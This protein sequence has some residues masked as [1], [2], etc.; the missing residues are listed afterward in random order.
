MQPNNKRSDRLGT[1][2]IVPLLLKLSVP[3]IIGMAIQAL[4]NVV[5]SI[6]IGRLSKE[7][8]SALSLAFPIQMV[9]IAVAVGTGIGTSALISRLLGEK[10]EHEAN[11]AAEH[12]LIITLFY[13]VIFGII[14]F[15]YSKELLRLFTDNGLL[16]E[17]GSQ[18]IR[19]IMIGSVAM[20]FP[21][22]SNNILRGE[23]NTFVPML[24]MLIGAIINIVLDPFLIFGIGFFPALG[25]E[26]AAYA[27]VFSR[28]IS[29]TFI[30]YILLFSNRNQLT[31]NIRDFQF[32]PKVLGAIYQV[33]LPAMIMQLLAS[34]MIGG[35]NKIVAEYSITAIAVV[36]IYFRLQ[37]F[38]F[39]PVFGLNQGYI[40]IMGYNY[41]HGQSERMKETFKYGLLISFLFTSGGFL[42][43]QIFPKPLISLF[44][45]D[46]E[47]IRIGTTALR[48][49]SLAFPI[50]G[51]AILGSTTFQAIGKG[52]PSLI[53]SILRQL[54]LLLPIML[55]L[56]KLYGLSALWFAFPLSE[57]VSGVLMVFWLTK[58]LRH[59]FAR[60]E[61]RKV[62]EAKG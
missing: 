60:M 52:M 5:D 42:L 33:G 10:K 56:G 31:L 48:R 8:L 55:I 7:A 22:I 35:V 59:V 21:M 30:G 29:G 25:V 32:D 28:I 37:S 62:V 4:Y 20:F 50:I 16:I 1:E 39:M 19:I 15:F 11:N 47:L 26:G 57:L 44:N 23:G 45:N 9:L 13:G 27:T 6:Y 14:G 41:G 18:Y 17:L 51:P 3:S 54:V 58:A 38:V 53:L 61:E 36:G 2:P 46:P 12:A 40:P 24:T 49:I 43:F 34:V